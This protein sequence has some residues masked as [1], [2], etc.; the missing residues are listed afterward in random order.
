MVNLLSKLTIP[1][2]M[3]FAGAVGDIIL[4]CNIWLDGKTVY[5]YHFYILGFG[6]G[7]FIVGGV[8]MFVVS[9]MHKS[10]D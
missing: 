6:F 9:M 8:W 5:D 4:F 2:T 1:A 3:A 10:V 7:M